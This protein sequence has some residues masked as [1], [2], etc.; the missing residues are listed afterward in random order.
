MP[1]R[2][3][4]RGRGKD[5]LVVGGQRRDSCP[6]EQPLHQP[7]VVPV[8]IR[9]VGK[10]DL[11]RLEVGALAQPHSRLHGDQVVDVLLRPAQ[12]RLDHHAAVGAVRWEEVVG[13]EI[14]GALRVVRAFHVEPDET[15][16]CLAR[17]RM[18]AMLAQTE[19]FAD[20]E[21]HLGELDR[22]VDLDAARRHALE[23]AQVLVPCGH[24]FRFRRYAFAEQIE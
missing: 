1:S 9:L 14:E 8:H 24:G 21:P 23:H 4:N 7:D 20:I 17:S 6:P 2:S 18:A 15:A 19:L 12:H 11:V 3:T 16:E 13:E 10:C 5:R 22:D